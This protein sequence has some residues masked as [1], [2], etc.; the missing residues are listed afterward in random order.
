MILYVALM[1]K[2]RCA[3]TRQTKFSV[4]AGAFPA[5]ATSGLCRHTLPTRQIHRSP[6]HLYAIQILGQTQLIVS[7]RIRLTDG[8]FFAKEEMTPLIFLG[9]LPLA[10][11]ARAISFRN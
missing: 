3:V 9:T 5:S 11:N 6:I 1:A 8:P 10:L 2:P 7:A 4:V